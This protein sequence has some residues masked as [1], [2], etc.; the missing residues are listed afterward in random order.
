MPEEN[1]PEDDL[2]CGNDE[3][4]IAEYFKESHGRSRSCGV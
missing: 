4:G 1:D 2:K 3:Q